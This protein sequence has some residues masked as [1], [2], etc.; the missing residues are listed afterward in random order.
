MN[1]EHHKSQQKI[2]VFLRL[3]W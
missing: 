1:K 2:R 3:S